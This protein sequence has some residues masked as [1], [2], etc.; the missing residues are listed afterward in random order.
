MWIHSAK[1]GVDV[2]VTP[3]AVVTR[4]AEVGDRVVVHPGAVVGGDPQYL[5]FDRKTPSWVRVGA[6]S[7]LREGVTLNRS[8]YEDRATEVGARCFF[9]ANFHAGY[10][11]AVADDV[12][13]AN[14]ALLDGHVEMVAFSFIGGN[15]AVHQ[16]SRSGA[17]VM[18][19]GV[20]PIISDVPPYCVV[21]DRN[22]VAGLNLVGLKR[23]GWSCEVMRELKEAYRAV[24]QPVG[25]MRAMA[26]TLR[27]DA[28]SEQARTFLEFFS[29]G[30]RPLARPRRGRE[31]GTE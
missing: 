18:V 7:T 11:C 10:D 21:A 1:L 29:D 19:A 15:A 5:A 31:Q 8:I 3:G 4:W 22:A 28:Q 23:R 16:F 2:E 12:V 24:M 26:A 13:L 6:D 25:N 17:V 14:G 30:K 9:M 27:P 20:A